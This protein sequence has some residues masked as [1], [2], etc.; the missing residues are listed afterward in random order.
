MVFHKVPFLDQDYLLNIY[1][2][3]LCNVSTMLKCILFADDTTIICSKYYLEELCTEVISELDKVND[4]FNI[5]KLSLNLN[6]S[7]FMLFS[8]SKSS[9]NVHITIK[10][11]I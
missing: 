6:K 11:F 7:N 10:I 8:S 3:D 2:Y 9:G 1:I 4:L 5:N